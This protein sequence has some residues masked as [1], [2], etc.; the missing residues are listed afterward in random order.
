MLQRKRAA[1]LTLSSCVWLTVAIGF[2]VNH[3]FAR[4][5]LHVAGTCVW[6]FLAVTESIALG[7]RFKEWQVLNE[8]LTAE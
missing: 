2:T 7:T 6:M 1:R 8:Q 3:V 4:E 5:D